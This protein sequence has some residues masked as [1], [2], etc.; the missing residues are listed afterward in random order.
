M[1]K[2]ALYMICLKKEGVP[3]V[4][5][6]AKSKSTTILMIEDCLKY[7]VVMQFWFI[8]IICFWPLVPQWFITHEFQVV[9]SSQKGA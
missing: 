3:L 7:I 2:L 4:H 9:L 1:D 6:I 5:K 8:P